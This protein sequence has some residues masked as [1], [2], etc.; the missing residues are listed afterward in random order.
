[1]AEGGGE[2]AY[3]DPDLGKKL[4]DDDDD[5]GQ[6]VNTTQPFKPGAASTPY[7]GD[8]YHRGE[9]MEMSTFPHEQSGLPDTSYTE[10][11]F[12]GE[13]I[14]LLGPFLHPDDKQEILER[15]K[16]KIRSWYKNVKFNEIDPVGFSK[17]KGKETEIVSFGTKGGE[18]KVFLSGEKGLQ[19]S[20]IKKFSTA[21][22][23]K[24][25]D[26]IVEDRDTIRE[27]KQ[28]LA[29]AENQLQQAETLSSQREE[30]KKRSGTSET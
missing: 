19:K 23:P 12:G 21:L 7:Q 15:A 26:I 14:P 27:M 20:F 17:Y 1:M 3:K 28:R 16:E 9:L 4:A 5:V 24:T 13:E 11:S 29:E 10:T 22:G 2:F 30:E 8:P 18:T 25:E 6:E